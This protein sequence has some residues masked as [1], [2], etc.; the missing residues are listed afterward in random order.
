MGIDR[1]MLGQHLHDGRNREHV[2]DPPLCDKS[3]GLVG[4]EPVALEQDSLDPR[5]TCTSWWMPAP[6]E[7][8]AR[9]REASCMR[10][11]WHQVAEVVRDHERHLAMGENCG[12]GTPRRA[13]R[14]EEPTRIVML[15]SR[16]RGTLSR[17]LHDERV[18]FLT[19]LRCSDGN[20]KADI[21]ERPR[22]LP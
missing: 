20:D 8:G 6:C 5:A 1:S 16:H 15:D 11:A 22:A 21:R 12:L 3:P 18:V 2:G 14:E 17:M 19:E 13:R 4:V 10:G 7:S 9:T